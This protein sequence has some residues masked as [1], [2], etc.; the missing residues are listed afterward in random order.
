MISILFVLTNLKI[1]N[2]SRLVFLRFQRFNLLKKLDK[3]S[4][5]RINWFVFL[6]VFTQH[7]RFSNYRNVLMSWSLNALILYRVSLTKSSAEDDTDINISLLQTRSTC[8]RKLNP[9]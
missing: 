8:S 3:L 7:Y 9:H 5:I 6:Y 4:Q 2:S 1:K